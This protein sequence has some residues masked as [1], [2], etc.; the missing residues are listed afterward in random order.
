MFTTLLKNKRK[1][2]GRLA[3]LTVLVGSQL[4][5]VSQ[6]NWANAGP[7][8]TPSRIRS[9]IIDNQ[10][11]SG[12]KLFAGSVTG[13]LFQSIDGGLNWNPLTDQATVK[14][15]SCL[16]QAS[17]GVLYVGTGENY[18]RANQIAKLTPGTGLYTYSNGNLN[19]VAGTSVFGNINKVV[20]NPTNSQRIYVASATGLYVSTDGG[21]TWA[22]GTSTTAVG[23]AF[24]IDLASNG[25]AY[26]SVGDIAGGSQ[27]WESTNGDPGTFV[28]NRTPTVALVASTYGRIEMAI[29]DN[30]PFKI[31]ISCA[32]PFLNSN[33]TLQGL[34][35][36]ENTAASWVP[37]LI[38]EGS[39]QLD[40]LRGG[41]ASWGDYSHELKVDPSSENT[42]WL[43][44][45][46][47][48]R[49]VKNGTTPGIGT[50]TRLG[51]D[52]APN[53]FLYLPKNVH[54]IIFKPTDANT[55]YIATD[56]AIYKT[57]DKAF[58]FIGAFK[59]LNATAFNNVAIIA[60]PNIATYIPTTSVTVGN[61]GTPINA[62]TGFVASGVSSGI[63]FYSGNYP[64]VTN[65][66]DYQTGEF[67]NVV[68]STILPKA[69]VVTRADGTIWRTSDYSTQDYAQFSMRS[70]VGAASS[71]NFINTAFNVTGTPFSVF[72]NRGQLTG[73]VSEVNNPCDSAIFYNDIVGLKFAL[74]TPTNA[75]NAN[76]PIVFQNIRPQ[77]AALYD[78]ISIVTSNANTCGIV[79]SQTIQVVPV[80]T[81]TNSNPTF[82]ILSG[83][84]SSTVNN[85]I[86]M[87][88]NVA[89][90]KDNLSFQFLT[91]PGP[92]TASCPSGTTTINAKIDINI[93]IYYKYVPKC[94]VYLTNNDIST[95]PLT[96][97]SDTIRVLKS[98]RNG[99]NN[100]PVK[101]A[102]PLSTRFAFATN[103]G[104]F[105]SRN[106]FD[107]SDAPSYHMISANDSIRIDGP[108]GVASTVT[109]ISPANARVK[110]LQ[111][112]PSGRE[113][114]VVRATTSGTNTISYIYRISHL[115]DMYDSTFANYGGRFN[116]AAT[117][118]KAYNASN[119]GA[120]TLKLNP[121]SP[122]RTTLIGRIDSVVTSISL[123]GANGLILTVAP[124][125]TSTTDG[126]V[127]ISNTSLNTA[128][129]ATNMSNFTNRTGTL[130]NNIKL[131]ASLS[132]MNDNGKVF[133]GTSNGVWMTNNI[134]TPAPTWNNANN[135]QMP[136]IEVY[137]I[138]QQTLPHWES[139]LSG[140]IFATTNGRGVWRSDAFYTQSFIGINE[141]T[142]TT[143]VG[144]L[145][146][147][148]NPSNGT[149]NFD[150]KTIIGEHLKM[151][152]VDLMGRLVLTEDLGKS[153]SD[154]ITYTTD[155]STL[156]NGIYLVSVKGSNGTN[157]IG[158]LILSK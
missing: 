85:F 127:Y 36:V 156:N 136:N 29:P 108:G 54:Q 62:Q 139:H 49:W 114:Y 74:T 133:L 84:S 60:K 3:V 67:N 140:V 103:K 89:S 105:V 51:S 6:I 41:G 30:N 56:G 123:L 17:N 148:P 18:A 22:L 55:M 70:S 58:S 106:M 153:Y 101:V 144:S 69:S 121:K 130:N 76:T 64:L 61:G 50:W 38:L 39:A 158:K 94:F 91:A 113:L 93:K 33:S 137:D 20:I 78:S 27:V 122:F 65:E 63:T 83:A 96:L 111:W 152:I 155:L 71:N 154:S 16:A 25:Y 35:V 23:Q 119:P 68:V 57:S 52:A 11:Q 100:T 135:N 90:L 107:F 47:L 73:T 14:N 28:T 99:A 157:H 43:G 142:A 37:T 34:F 82:S 9:L 149:L 134:N 98:H 40:P 86:T 7:V 110:F 24:D 53:T 8:T 126:R 19:L 81:G 44:G 13:G 129:T 92:S 88:Y 10:D 146:M 145:K 80:Y 32:S 42:I 21:S 120:S 151:E 2:V 102:L 59:N 5:M 147:Y 104:I 112:A 79:P 124:T 15:I 115:I 31:Y 138:K 95:K 143:K 72:E 75:P 116:T 87:D 132:E 109:A 97:R 118:Y 141:I 45:Y 150:C 125:S 131:F 66:E 26:T 46:A 117:I 12:N 77:A 4:T 48:Y 128:N 1:L